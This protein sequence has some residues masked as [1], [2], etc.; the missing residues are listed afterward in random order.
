MR[1]NIFINC[2]FQVRV[3][4]VMKRT[5]KVSEKWGFFLKKRRFTV[6]YRQ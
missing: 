5:S 3:G 1:V 6:L 4:K 2:S